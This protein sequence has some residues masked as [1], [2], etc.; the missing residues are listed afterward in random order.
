MIKKVIISAAGQGKRMRHLTKDKPKHLIEVRG[1]PFLYYLL[2]NL[3]EAGLK[4]IIIVIGYKKEVLE[5]FIKKY[6]PNITILNQSDFVGEEYGTACPIKCAEHLIKNKNFLSVCGD[7]LY[8]VADIKQLM[9]DDHYNY[10]AGIVDEHPETH[11][12]LVAKEKDLSSHSRLEREDLLEKIVE[13]SNE[14]M[15]NLVNTGMYKFTPEIFQVVKKISLSSRGE[16]EITDA[17]SLLAKENKV[18]IKKIKDYWLEFTRP[19]DI[20]SVSNFLSQHFK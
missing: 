13:K 3:K 6:D 19:E 20:I 8:S 15:G 2:E 16:Y 4:E 18:K 7:N 14:S 12:V 1:H 9:I 11:G 5:K 17:I 10:I